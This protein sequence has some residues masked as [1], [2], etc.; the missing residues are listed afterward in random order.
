ME[1]V[2]PTG[3]T[4]CLNFLRETSRGLAQQG[5]N[6]YCSD[7]WCSGALPRSNPT[8]RHSGYFYKCNGRNYVVKTNSM[9]LGRVAHTGQEDAS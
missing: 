3:P 4:E 7:R 2:T 5:N 8:D 1:R 9:L 6:A